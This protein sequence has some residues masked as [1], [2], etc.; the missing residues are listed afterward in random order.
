MRYLFIHPLFPGQ[1]HKLMEQL[2]AKHSE[3]TLQLRQRARQSIVDR[4]SLQ[5]VLP[6]HTALLDSL[7]AARAR[8]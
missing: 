2:A 5:Q 7:L 1:F 3:A 4:Y 8:T 6:R